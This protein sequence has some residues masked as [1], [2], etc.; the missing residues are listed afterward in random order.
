MHVFE[1]SLHVTGTRDLLKCLSVSLDFGTANSSIS[2]QFNYKE[3]AM[4]A[5]NVKATWATLPG[6]CTL[7]IE[8]YI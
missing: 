2:L 4:P 1:L 7:Y 6:Q 8:V 3:K 5:E